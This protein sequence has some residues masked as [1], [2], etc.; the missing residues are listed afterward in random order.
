MQWHPLKPNK[1][2][3]HEIWLLEAGVLLQ[4]SHK[5]VVSL[6][7]QRPDISR[8]LGQQHPK[9]LVSLHT[10]FSVTI[11]H[12]LWLLDNFDNNPKICCVISY[13]Y[14]LP[15]Q[16]DISFL[17]SFSRFITRLKF[18]PF[19]THGHSYPFG[20]WPYYPTYNQNIITCAYTSQYKSRLP[21]QAN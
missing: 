19:S 20:K 12:Q 15:P 2:D 10:S 21:L 18:K 7:M 8:F 11:D 13:C 3:R 4:R 9:Q 14:W 16:I 1:T 6:F 17:K 5:K